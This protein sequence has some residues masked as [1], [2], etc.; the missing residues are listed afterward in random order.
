VTGVQTCA[1]PIYRLASEG[2]PAG[3][4]STTQSAAPGTPRPQPAAAPQPASNDEPDDQGDDDDI[5]HD[6]D[7]GQ[8][9]DD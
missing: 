5:G 2:R 9:D 8:D 1:L 7:I 4:A 6:D 3:A